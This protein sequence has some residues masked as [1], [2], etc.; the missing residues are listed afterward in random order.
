MQ[1]D[2]LY[3]NNI[4][5]ISTQKQQRYSV[6]VPAIRKKKD[7]RPSPIQESKMEKIVMQNDALYINNIVPIS[8]QK[9][10]RYSVPVP[11]IRKKDVRPSRSN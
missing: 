11:A 4:V 9:Q 3:I 1:N 7:V 5:P 6:P 2:A 8:T 10:Q